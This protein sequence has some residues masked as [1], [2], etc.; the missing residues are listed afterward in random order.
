[1]PIYH[2]ELAENSLKEAAAALA[3]TARY[4]S[5]CS[6]LIAEDVISISTL[7]TIEELATQIEEQAG[8]EVVVDHENKEVRFL[9]LDATS[10][11]ENA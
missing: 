1:M 11:G 8:I 2:L 3:S 10:N 9:P 6:E 5:Y 4:S 7:G